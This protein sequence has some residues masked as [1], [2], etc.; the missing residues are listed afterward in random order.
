MATSIKIMIERIQL[1]YI[2]IQVFYPMIVTLL[3]MLCVSLSRA[4]QCDTGISENKKSNII[5]LMYK[6]VVNI[7]YLIKPCRF[8]VVLETSDHCAML[9]HAVHCISTVMLS[10]IPCL[11]FIL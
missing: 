5:C 10:D 11:I 6:I 8:A 1:R 7:I 2:L 3:S 4:G 9:R